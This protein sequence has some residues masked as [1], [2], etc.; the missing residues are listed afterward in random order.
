[1]VY[2]FIINK[3]YFRFL[4]VLGFWG[5]DSGKGACKDRGCK[6]SCKQDSRKKGAREKSRCKESRLIFFP[7]QRNSVCR[8]LGI[9]RWPGRTFKSIH[10]RLVPEGHPFTAQ[11]ICKWRKDLMEDCGLKVFDQL[12]GLSAYRFLL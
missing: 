8:N 12:V 9:K 4:G 7:L 6:E 1:M 10:K 11:D 5:K 3:F 2:L